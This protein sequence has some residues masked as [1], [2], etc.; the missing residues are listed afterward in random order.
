MTL[1]D[2]HAKY[3][4]HREHGM[5]IPTFRGPEVVQ[6]FMYVRIAEGSD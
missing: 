1:A 6:A 5:E 2:Y 3:L 4:A